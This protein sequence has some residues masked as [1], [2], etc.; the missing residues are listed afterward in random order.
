MNREAVALRTPVLTTFEGKHGAVDEDLI[1]TGRM[2][3][4]R[5]PKTQLQ[6][7]RRPRDASGGSADRIRRDPRELLALA[8]R[9]LESTGTP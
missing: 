1:A 8:L 7:E 9:S 3:Q 2:G 5:D 6:V 4:L